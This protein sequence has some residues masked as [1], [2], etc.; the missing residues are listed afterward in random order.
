MTRSFNEKTIIPKVRAWLLKHY[1]LTTQ[2]GEWTLLDRA[3]ACGYV[4][5][6]GG[7]TQWFNSFLKQGRPIPESIYTAMGYRCEVIKHKVSRR[8]TKL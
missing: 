1:P 7:V 2:G 4:G 3:D 8:Y 6:S 5:P